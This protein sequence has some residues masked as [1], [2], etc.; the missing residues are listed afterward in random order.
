[1]EKENILLLEDSPTLSAIYKG[2]LD[3]EPYKVI[4]AENGQQALDI[5]NSS[6]PQILLLDLN[7]PDM[8]GMDILKYIQE[9]A[10]P[11]IV[12][13]LTAHGS[14]DIAVDAMKY[15]AF[16]FICKPVEAKR[17]LI[18]IRNA[19]KTHELNQIIDV[20]REQYE[21][22]EFSGFIGA[23]IA[24]Q[25]VYRIIESAAPS[26]AT[27]F[28]TGESGTG[29]ELC[30]EAVHKL[31]PRKE[32][33]FIALNCAAIPK[34]LMESEIFGHIKGAFTGASS[35]RKGAAASADGGTLFLDEI[36][37]MDLDLQSKI[38]RFIQSST[39]QKVGSSK[40]EKVDVRFVCATNK[41]PYK[42]VQG[43]RFREDLY[44]RLHVIPIILPPLRNR[45]QD[46]IQIAKQFLYDISKEENK[47]FSH[48]SMDVDNILLNYGWPGNVRELENVIRNLVV[49][50][51][52]DEVT[53]E[54]LP[55]PLN[56]SKNKVVS[57]ESPKAVTGYT[58]ESVE[59]KDGYIMPLWLVEKNA[60]E[61]AIHR[62]DGNIPKAAASLDV[63]PSTIYRKKQAWEEL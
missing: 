61:E 47:A 32:K 34:D 6:C 52:A 10:L 26:T 49:L 60:I 46:I 14:V 59:V 58:V 29:K 22:Q 55:Y 48:F 57:I 53:I 35:E 56:E 8:K 7:L 20:Y 18:T 38:L 2:Y 50:N 27:V 31:S 54:M 51:N 39:F 25:S 13:V 44:Y 19:A 62:C 21:R 41:E 16:D 5:I 33:P 11:I 36:C 28:I 37:E 9:Q 24:M 23:S 42:E 40:L 45:G 1:M 17:L 12:V 43:G 63:S 4:T 3:K 15:G 30:A